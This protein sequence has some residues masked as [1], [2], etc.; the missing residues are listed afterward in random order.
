MM[1]LREIT[2]S[3]KDGRDLLLWSQSKLDPRGTFVVGRWDVRHGIWT[4][5]FA[6]E[7]DGSLIEEFPELCADLPYPDEAV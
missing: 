4:T 6:D 5:G 3:D 2:D 1:K 7:I